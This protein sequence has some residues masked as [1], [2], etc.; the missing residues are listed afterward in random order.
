VAQGVTGNGI[1]SGAQ[2]A[3]GAHSRHGFDRPQ[4]AGVRL[5]RGSA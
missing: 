5:G 3:T 4:G 1:T 2:A